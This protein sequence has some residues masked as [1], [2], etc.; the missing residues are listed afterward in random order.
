MLTC[1]CNLKY[2]FVNSPQSLLLC[3]RLLGLH[4][5]CLIPEISLFIW[6]KMYAV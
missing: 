5:Y 2:A 6:I 1:T 3:G 4:C